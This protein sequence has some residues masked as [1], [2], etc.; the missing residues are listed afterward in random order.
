MR[1]GT[2]FFDLTIY[3]KTVNRFWPLWAVNLVIWLFVLPFDGLITFGD[4]IDGGRAGTVMLRWARNVGERATEFGVVFALFAGLVVAMAVCSHLYNNRSA[5]FMGALPCRR[6]G[7]FLSTYLAGLTMLLAPNVVIFLLTL[8]IEAVAGTVVWIS[9]LYWL[10]AMS[11]MEF[12]FYS[13]AVCLGQFA[14][15]ILALPVFYGVFNALAIAVWSLMEWVLSVYYFGYSSLGGGESVV[16]WLTPVIPFIQMDIDFIEINGVITCSIDGLWVAAVYAAVAVALTACAMLLYRRRHLETAGDIV[17]VRA[18][19]PVFKYGVAVCAGMFGGVLLEQIFGLGEIGMMVFVLIWG[20]VGYFVAQMLLDKSV[21]VFKKWKGAAVVTA[22][23]LL[24]FA[25]IGFDLT[26]YETRVPA[27]SNVAS[28]EI[29]GLHSED[30]DSGYGLYDV[31]LT[32]PEDIA[33]VVALHEGI[34]YVGEEYSVPVRDDTGWVSFNVDYTLKSGVVMSRRYSMR[35]DAE[36]LVRAQAV[37][38]LYHVRYQA[39]HLDDIAKWEAEGYELVSVDLYCEDTSGHVIDLSANVAARYER[40]W[41]AVME[42]FEAGRIGLH[43]VSGN[44]L[45]KGHLTETDGYRLE[46]LWSKWLSTTEARNQ[47]V[48]FF[49]LPQ[50][51]STWAALEGAIYKDA[52]NTYRDNPNDNPLWREG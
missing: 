16:S 6:E 3:R 38:D 31:V 32:D 29:G 12:F 39:Y 42:D 15:H 50:S 19:R 47:V 41:A 2:S 44:N 45:G 49:V 13:F 30:Y 48:S 10:A 17:A 9:L 36:L 8:L 27:V 18:M 24:L 5:N 34:V 52:D 33:A 14:G 21:R 25:V 1:S 46:F 28:V 35:M 11:A 7:Q 37:R 4:Y 40:L 51:T 23:F 22:A 26:G 43:S 20:I